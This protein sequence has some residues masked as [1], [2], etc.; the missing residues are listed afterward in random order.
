MQKSPLFA[1]ALAL[2]ALT[3][4][5][6]AD[7]KVTQKIRLDNPQLKAY[8]DTMTPQQRA[9][10][11]GRSDSLLS[12]L[13][14]QTTTV[15]FSGV[16]TRADV[17]TLTYLFNSQTHKCI[18]VVNRKKHTYTEQ[19]YK[20]PVT[21]PFQTTVKNAGPGKVIGGHPARHYLLTATTPSLPGT[22]IQGDIWA[23]QD[24][25][26]PPAMTGGGPFSALESLLQKV[27]GYPLTATVVATGSP[28]GDT[29]FKS[30]VIA[31]SKA[32]L[33]VS[34]FAIP[35]GYTKTSTDTGS[36]M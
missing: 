8:L 35:A 1:A 34:V 31:I 24:L 2:L 22:V 28:L 29:T 15:Y 27:K 13:G 18:V 30:S 9:Q 16:K 21:S 10:Q 6:H 26:T 3:G 20:A 5:A 36:G 11:M 12:G 32:A 7:L 14:P 25:P 33:P 19:P 17:G 23:A 4:S